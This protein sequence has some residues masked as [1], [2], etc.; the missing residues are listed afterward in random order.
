MCRA[1]ALLQ[2]LG[3]WVS[4]E[5][6][7]SY[8]SAAGLINPGSMATHGSNFRL[9]ETGVYYASLPEVSLKLDRQLYSLL[10]VSIKGTKQNLLKQVSFPS[11]VQAM[12]VLYKHATTDAG[13]LT[14]TRLKAFPCGIRPTQSLYCSAQGGDF[15][16]TTLIKIVLL[17]V[18]IILTLT[19]LLIREIGET[20]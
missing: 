13:F 14:L 11:Y 20:W 6:S 2:L 8:A 3:R 17:Y 18:P 10:K 12:I 7:E 1:A 4:E 5:D 16:N 9:K 19:L 15:V